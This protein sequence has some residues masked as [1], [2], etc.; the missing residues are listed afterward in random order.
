M[1]YAVDI[2]SSCKEKAGEFHEWIGT[3]LAMKLMLGYIF[4]GSLIPLSLPFSVFLL[5]SPGHIV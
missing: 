4:E 2:D 5:C 1:Q 3:G